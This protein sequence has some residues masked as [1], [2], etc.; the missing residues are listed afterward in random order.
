MSISVKSAIDFVLVIIFW[1]G[2][3]ACNHASRLNYTITIQSVRRKVVN[4]FFLKLLKSNKLAS[5]M[6]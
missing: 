1:V 6:I 5:F 2:N 4:N 3:Q